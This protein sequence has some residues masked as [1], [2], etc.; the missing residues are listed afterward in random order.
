VLAAT[1]QTQLFKWA[2]PKIVPCLGRY[3][4]NTVGHRTKPAGAAHKRI[5]TKTHAGGGRN[6]AQGTLFFG[7]FFTFV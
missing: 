6:Q 7:V 5:N 2:Q 1:N 3:D 4:S